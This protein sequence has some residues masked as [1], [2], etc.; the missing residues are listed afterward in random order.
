MFQ[1][2]PAVSLMLKVNPPGSLQ[3]LVVYMASQSWIGFT[4]GQLIHRLWSW[5]RHAQELE[6]RHGRRGQ[7]WV[8]SNPCWPFFWNVSKGSSPDT[9]VSR[10][11]GTLKSSILVG[12]SLVNHP[13]CGTPIYG[14]HH[15]DKFECFLVTLGWR[16][17]SWAHW[18]WLWWL[19][20][21]VIG[22]NHVFSGI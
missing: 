2:F 19:L 16:V 6:R 15:M 12:F 5:C 11:G 17:F 8:V 18:S 9:E 20:R 14:N 22:A 13:F 4:N 1:L 10:N 21:K 3:V 7:S